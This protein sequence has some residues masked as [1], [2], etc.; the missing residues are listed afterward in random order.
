LRFK[1]DNEAGAKK[2]HLLLCNIET[3]KLHCKRVI[4]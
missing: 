1:D 3:R 2:G 4:R